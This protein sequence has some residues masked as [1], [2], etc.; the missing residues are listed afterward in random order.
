M[1]RS[2]AL[3]AAAHRYWLPMN[4]ENVR[5]ELQQQENSDFGCKGVKMASG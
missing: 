4:P 2:P 5:M 3:P 1:M